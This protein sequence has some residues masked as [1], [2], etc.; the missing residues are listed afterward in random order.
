VGDGE[1]FEDVLDGP[2]LASAC[3]AARRAAEALL[4]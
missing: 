4:R 1:P 2:E 3:A